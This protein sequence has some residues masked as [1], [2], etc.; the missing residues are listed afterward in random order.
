MSIRPV[1]PPQGAWYA[2]EWGRAV[3]GSYDAYNPLVLTPWQAEN[4]AKPCGFKEGVQ[5][6][7]ARPVPLTGGVA[8]IEKTP[9][10]MLLHPAGGPMMDHLWPTK[11]LADP[12]E[13]ELVA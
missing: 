5:Y 8:V 11:T 12:I 1:P 9:D 13:I 3:A 6:I 10:G 7:L 2:K 4:L